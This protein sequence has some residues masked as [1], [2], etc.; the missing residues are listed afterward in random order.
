VSQDYVFTI[1]QITR[2]LK[3]LLAQEA[4]LQN[5]A[6]RGEIADFVRHSSGHLYFTLKDEFSQLRCV[7]FREEAG[8]LAFRPES[9]ADVVARGT[10][11]I[12][13][14]RGQ[15]QLVVRELASAGVGDLYLAFE[16][17]RR[18]L[19]EEGLFDEARKRPLPPF[20]RR[21]AAI[22]SS[23]GAAIHDVLT[24]LRTRWPAADVI[25]IPTPV[26]GPGSA[27]G[28]VQSLRRLSQ[29]EGIEVALLVRGG[30]SFE[31]LAGFND[32]AVARAIAGAPVPVIT[33]IGHE[34][35]VTI[36]DLVADRRA[37]TPTAA[38]VA[39][40][41][42]RHALLIRVRAVR[43]GLADRLRRLVLRYR[44]ELALLR[45]RP[46]LCRPRLVFA[47]HR[48]RLDDAVESIGR[49]LRDLSR[50]LSERLLRAR[51]KLDALRP[52]AVL[53][54]GYSLTRLP[55]GTIV[56]SVRQVS[57]GTMAEVVFADGSAR[58]TIREILPPRRDDSA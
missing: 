48:Q 51:D 33:G 9:G 34:T 52:E 1:R 29:V 19:A 26:S 25:L 44:R 36:A 20:P 56:R 46:V 27:A 4:T 32:E 30:G 7:M 5:V 15:Y 3:A 41:P 39:A 11:T 43:R 16:R 2:Y 53:G 13:E 28:I 31:E 22:T 47:D 42:D 57:V 50:S 58:V 10:I 6:V 18:R 17:L 35:D 55:D 8:S 40:T 45:A 24:T 37:A 12:Y 23:V 38:A 21:I 49:A 54:R 14:A